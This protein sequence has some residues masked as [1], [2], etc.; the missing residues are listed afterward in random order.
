MA[1]VTSLGILQVLTELLIKPADN[2]GY[3]DVKAEFEV[4]LEHEEQHLINVRNWLSEC[5]FDSA[6]V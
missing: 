6:E 4:A 1:G 5:V 2:L 3:P